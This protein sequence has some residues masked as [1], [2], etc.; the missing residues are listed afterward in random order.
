MFFLWSNESGQ[1]MSTPF[2]HLIYDILKV[3]RKKVKGILL[4]EIHFKDMQVAAQLLVSI[5]PFFI[6]II[7]YFSF[8]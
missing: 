7:L 4:E 6:R 5:Q 3:F 1:S 2:G 8:H